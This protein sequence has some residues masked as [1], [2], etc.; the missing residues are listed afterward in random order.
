VG[1]R[2]ISTQFK[3]TLPICRKVLMGSRK[4]RL[5]NYGGNMGLK[6][7]LLFGRQIGLQVDFFGSLDMNS[8]FSQIVDLN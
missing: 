8:L 5:D 2:R 1:R 3:K 4:T 7:I 6:K